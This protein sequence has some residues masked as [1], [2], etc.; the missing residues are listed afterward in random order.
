MIKR[1][2]K[3]PPANLTILGRKPRHW[4]RQATAI[5]GKTSAYTLQMML[6]KPDGRAFT[7]K[8]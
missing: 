5:D 2:S 6:L 7:K 8:Y 4:S 3:L 1:A